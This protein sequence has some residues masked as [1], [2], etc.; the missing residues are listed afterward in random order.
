MLNTP[1]RAL[2][3]TQ[4]FPSLRHR[5]S[6]LKPI[7]V[8]ANDEG[9]KPIPPKIFEVSP[10]MSLADHLALILPDRSLYTLKVVITE[11]ARPFGCDVMKYSAGRSF[12]IIALLAIW[13][14]A[15]PASAD[16]PHAPTPTATPKPKPTPKP[17]ATPKPKPTPKPTATP[18]PKA[19]PTITATPQPTV[20]PTPNG[21]P[22]ETPTPSATP[23]FTPTPTVNSG[24]L[25]IFPGAQGFG[26]RTVA[27]S[28]RHLNPPST[29]IYKITSLADAGIG[30]LRECAEA[31]VP[32]TCVFELSGRIALV[33]PIKVRNPYLTIAGQTAPSPGIMLT[34]AGLI[35]LTH[36][37]L[38]QHLQVRVGD[39]PNG[40][41]P[42]AR[43]GISVQGATAAY[44]V[45]FDHISVSWALDENV[46]T[47]YPNTNDVT[48][49]NSIIAEGLYHSIH[50]DGPHSKGLMI[51]EHSK[52]ITVVG[53]LF[54]HNQD[55]NPYVKPGAVAEVVNN[56]VYN[57]GGTS[58]SNIL[59]ISDY[60]KTG[61]PTQL[62]F[63]GNYYKPGPQSS[64]KPPVYGSSVDPYTRVFVQ[65]NYGPTRTAATANEW[66][67]TSLLESPFRSVAPVFRPNFDSAQQPASTYAAV[68]QHAGARP[69]ERNEVDRRIVAE[70]SS[71]SGSIKDCVEGCVA[72]AGGWPAV[73]VV[74]RDVSVPAQPNGDD[75]GDGYTNLEEL[76]HAR[77][78]EVEGR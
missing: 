46:S 15:V 12:W 16:K 69:A 57:W 78:A 50:P 42:T 39:D 1:E 38:V 64:Q 31:S 43:D 72:N 36:D 56:V 26:T 76:L 22:S 74:R 48:F 45:V 41:N 33:A 32:R 61:A 13:L 35:I 75:D 40:P 10:V 17:T 8:Y 27:G 53:N 71:G 66:S 62:N 2:T 4:F 47:G 19:T 51:S 25:P 9:R 58:G 29:R 7:H 21:T 65:G 70:V 28:G 34:G 67:I 14:H 23:Q 37:A 52:N 3:L 55:R 24:D 60:A 18:K 77:A 73:P 59:N 68:L 20:Q 49:S 63:T 44:N 30:S 5:G 11:G 54:A 6:H